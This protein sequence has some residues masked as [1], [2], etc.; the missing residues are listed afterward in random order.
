MGEFQADQLVALGMGD[1]L[2]LGL[3]PA[4]GLGAR[5]RGSGWCAG[6]FQQDLRGEPQGATH[7][8]QGPSGGNVPG[9]GKLKKLF[10]F[11]IT[12]P[13]KNRDRQGKTRPS[14][15]LRFVL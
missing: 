13:D 3:D 4:G 2:S 9:G 5:W 8:D 11:L 1:P 15:A 14:A 6:D 7:S 10:A 12:T